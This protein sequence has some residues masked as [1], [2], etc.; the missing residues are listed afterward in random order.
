[1]RW[2]SP[3]YLASWIGL[4]FCGVLFV[5]LWGLFRVTNLQD[6][7]GMQEEEMDDAIHMAM[8]LELEFKDQMQSWKNL[9]LRGDDPQMFQRYSSEFER[10]E[11]SV[12]SGLF[13]N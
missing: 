1:M 9:L 13:L 5:A 12:Q 11:S 6:V 3:V 8:D 4:T 7:Q 2:L 10:T